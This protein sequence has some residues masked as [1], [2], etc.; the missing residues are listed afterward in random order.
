VEQRAIA[1]AA[2]AAAAVGDDAG[3]RLHVI[4]V[5]VG[6]AIPPPSPQSRALTAP[7]AR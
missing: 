1:V 3:V 6:P 4:L 2:A 5:L 7:I